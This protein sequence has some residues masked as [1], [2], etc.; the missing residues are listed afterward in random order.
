[1]PPVASS[2]SD[3]PTVRPPAPPLTDD[4]DAAGELCRQEFYTTLRR[5][6]FGLFILAMVGTAILAAGAAW[7]CTEQLFRCGYWW[8][9]TL[10]H[11]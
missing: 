5:L 6:S 3:R 1:M 4:P 9:K 2:P 10:S 8:A 7:Y 11:L